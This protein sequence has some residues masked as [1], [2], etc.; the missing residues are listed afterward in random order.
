MAL[1]G[2]PAPTGLHRRSKSAISLVEFS[3]D[4]L[5]GQARQVGASFPLP[6]QPPLQARCP[7]PP[8]PLARP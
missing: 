7:L 8:A 1:S 4:P 6:S 2:S 3:W 5:S